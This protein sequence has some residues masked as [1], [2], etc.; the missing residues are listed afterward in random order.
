LPPSYLPY[1]NS[2]R[3]AKRRE[4]GN[5]PRI[6][7]PV[8]P[9]PTLHT[10]TSGFLGTPGHQGVGRYSFQSS[11]ECLS[12]W[13][14]MIGAALKELKAEISCASDQVGGATVSAERNPKYRLTAKSPMGS[15]TVEREP[16]WPI[17][18][19]IGHVTSRS[20]LK[21]V[22]AVS[23]DRLSHALTRDARQRA[24]GKYLPGALIPHNASMEIATMPS[25]PS[26]STAK[27]PRDL[28]WCGSKQ[29]TATRMSGSRVRSRA[30]RALPASE[31]FQVPRPIVEKMEK[32]ARCLWGMAT[33]RDKGAICRRFD[34]RN[35]QVNRERNGGL[36]GSDAN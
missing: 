14:N 15:P 2:A 32:K 24:N 18:R 25:L 16:A 8:A 19:L 20:S 22:I 9:R 5:L 30:S 12:R 28:N 34:Q 6:P 3:I 26:T 10:H 23:S 35:T 27:W 11:P 31:R 4:A 29:T 13:K 1:N 7:P 36:D 21:T 17:S 33:I